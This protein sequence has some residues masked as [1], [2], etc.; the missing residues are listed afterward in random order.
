MLSLR[1]R[2]LLRCD[3]IKS[4][5][6]KI[7]LPFMDMMT[8]EIDPEFIL[9]FGKGTSEANPAGENSSLIFTCDV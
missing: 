5:I 1:C 2:R 4:L 7:K 8:L 6:T 3:F 9:F